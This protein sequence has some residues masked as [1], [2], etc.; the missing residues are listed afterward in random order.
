MVMENRQEE[1]N[2]LR[3][4]LSS[5]IDKLNELDEGLDKTHDTLFAQNTIP[6][7]IKFCN[8]VFEKDLITYEEVISKTKVREVVLV[9]HILCFILRQHTSL[10]LKSI[11]Q[12][13]G[14]R[15]H[16][17]VIHGI[18]RVLNDL[19]C[20]GYSEDKIFILKVLKHFNVSH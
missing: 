7:V 17:T 15:D 8:E 9:R 3:G 5:I 18:N 2:Q 14:N 20:K 1:I 4:Q 19:S 12:K 13:L 16:S 6:N 11:G 10:S